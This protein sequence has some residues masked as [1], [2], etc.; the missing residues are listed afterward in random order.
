MKRIYNHLLGLNNLRKFCG[1]AEVF[2]YAKTDFKLEI[3]DKPKKGRVLVLAPHADDDVFGCGGSIAL[4]VEQ[5]D[6]VKII[7][8][9]D[10]IAEKFSIFNFQF[11]IKEEG[12]IDRKREALEAAKVLKVTNIEFWG[13]RENKFIVDKKNIARL[14]KVIEEYKP[15]IIYCPSFTDPNPDHYEVGKMLYKVLRDE[16]CEMSQDSVILLYEVWS[17]VYA[18]RL[19]KIDSVIEQKKA[20]IRCHKS[21][22][23]DRSY[24]DAIIGLNQYRAGMFNAGKY[25]EA[26][27]EMSAELYLKLFKKFQLD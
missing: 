12:S 2:K 23:S 18:N 6:K 3:L 14:K 17:P 11:S 8:L 16:K 1:N 21:Q 9:A 26:F 22:L 5:G 13:L 20:A 27:A 24:F 25:A 15:E 7:Y 19:I 10:D 4:H